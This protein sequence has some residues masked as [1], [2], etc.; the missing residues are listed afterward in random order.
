MADSRNNDTSKAPKV[1][2]EK[3][4]EKINRFFEERREREF[5]QDEAFSKAIT[6]DSSKA[7][8][9]E[10]VRVIYRNGIDT[11]FL[12]YVIALLCFGAVM[13]FSASYVYAEQKYDDSSYFIV[14][15][16]IFALAAIA[17]TVPFVIY[18]RPAF[19]KCFGTV[20]YVGSAFLL[21]LVLLPIFSW[22]AGG[23]QRWIDLGFI[24]IQP[25]EIA[26]LAVVMML[27]FYMSKYDRQ[28]TS[29]IDGKA[30]FKYGVIYP[31]CIFGLICGLVALEKHISGL[32]I[33]GMIGIAVMFMGGT[34]IK[35]IFL[36][37][38]GIAA[39]GCLLILVSDY[40]QDR[41]N[42]WINID[43]VDPLGSAWQTLQGLYAIG[44]GGLF[45]VG[46]G[47][48]RQKYG[49]VSQ[50]QNDFVFTIICEELGFFGA[51]LVVVLFAL[52]VIR[53]FKI[54]ANA[55]DKYTAL[56]VFGLTFKVALQTILNIAVVT[57]SMPNTGISLPFFSS[58]GTSLALQIFEM[59]IILSVSRFSTVKRR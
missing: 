56:L 36:I 19:W 2:K 11:R 12:V 9:R 18:A 6:P 40:A 3:I 55:P 20:C 13:S 30:N 41:V 31:V 7:P 34:R 26:K 29:P 59:G 53:G 1:K 4:T 54:A 35:W 49:Y 5:M 10:E 16:I 14:R 24:T 22:S 51:L 58:G 42:T 46:L 47:N 43:K 38:C 27:A 32:M 48:S 57:N 39:A 25:S 52:L 44:S 28:I 45:G 33:I 15:Y 8:E 17:I 37:I 21:L 23:A 50:P